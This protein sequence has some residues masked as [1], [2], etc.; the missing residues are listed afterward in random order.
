MGY[1]SHESPVKFSSGEIMI[2]LLFSVCV[3]CLLWETVL[4]GH[5]LILRQDASGGW[6]F[7]HGPDLAWGPDFE[8][9]C[10]PKVSFVINEIILVFN[11]VIQKWNPP[12]ARSSLQKRKGE[13]VFKVLRSVFTEY[14]AP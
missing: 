3:Y 14:N 9:V 11:D 1:K 4:V 10:R 2:K 7:G 5:I 12:L 8:H 13:P 6:K